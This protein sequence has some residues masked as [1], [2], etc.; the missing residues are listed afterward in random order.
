M[1]ARLV[2]RGALRHV[3]CLLGLIAVS[4]GCDRSDSAAAPPES[5]PPPPPSAPEPSASEPD[6]KEASRAPATPIET[7]RHVHALRVEGRIAELEAFLL[8]EQ[9]ADVLD[10]IQSM[11]QLLSANGVLQRAV[12]ERFGSASTAAFDRSAAGNAIGVFSHDVRAI[13]ERVDGDAAMVVIQVAGR[14]PLDDVRLI[15]R[16]RR[17]LIG[18]D[19]PDPKAAAALRELAEVMTRAAR[20]LARTE[21]TAVELKRELASSEAAVG[22]RLAQRRQDT[23]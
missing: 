14:V 4:G 7:V 16:S 8:D 12:K 15:R 2:K 5:A 17:W 22:R 18:T 1:V 11:D 20:R 23:P 13:S 9:R 21:M 10:L 19:T 6:L 3:G